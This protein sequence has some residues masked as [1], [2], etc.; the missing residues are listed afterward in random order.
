MKN[1]K[2][3]K[4]RDRMS[5]QCVQCGREQLIAYWDYELEYYIYLSESTEG[6]CNLCDVTTCDASNI[7]ANPQ[8][9]SSAKSNSK[10]NPPTYLHQPGKALKK[11]LATAGID[12][13]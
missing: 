2:V 7:H 11:T 4:S 12:S 10:S 3:K 5:M 13:K 9:T 6:L 8:T 1:A